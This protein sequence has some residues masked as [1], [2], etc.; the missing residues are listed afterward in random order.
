MKSRIIIARHGN[1]FKKG[2]TPTRVGARTDLSLVEEQR[3]RS[4]GKFLYEHDLI[5]DIIYASPLKR[6][7]QTAELAIEEMHIDKRI[8]NLDS[9][10]EI[11]YGPDEN[12]TEEEVMRRL[13]NGNLD[14]GKKI[15]DAWDKEAIVPYG[16]LVN[17]KAI[18]NTWENFAN[19]FEHIHK[20]V[21]I[22]T[23][24][25]IIRFA[26]YLTGDFASFSEKHAIKVSTG[27]VCIFEKEDNERHWDCVEWNIKPF[28]M[29]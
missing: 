11:D 14:A 9:F 18:I 12:K 19:N 20:T 1:T 13:G 8:I 22:V 17:P 28:T 21:L 27:G 3:G 23:S 26:P 29:Y 16:W 6:A 5:P 4:I 7:K 10:T 15:I 2:E 24:N 25:G